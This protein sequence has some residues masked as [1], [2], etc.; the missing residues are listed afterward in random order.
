MQVCSVDPGDAA[1]WTNVSEAQKAEFAKSGDPRSLAVESCIP[2]LHLAKNSATTSE[3]WGKII[4][5]K[6]R[7][8]SL[9]ARKLLSR[10]SIWLGLNVLIFSGLL[11]ADLS[12]F[13]KPS[14]WGDVVP[15][16]INM[17]AGGLVSFF[18]YWLVVYEPERRKRRVIKENLCK[19]YLGIKEDIGNPP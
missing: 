9:K 8:M 2:H 7:A 13:S 10:V 3:T 4:A 17:L 15:L 16:A 11:G 19:M 12:G 14:W 6:D 5:K 18:F 1:P